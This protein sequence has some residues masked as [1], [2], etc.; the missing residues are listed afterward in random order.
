[1][2]EIASKSKDITYHQVSIEEF[3]DNDQNMIIICSHSFPY[4]K[5]KG[6]VTSKF[7][8]LLKTM[9]IYY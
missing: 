6:L 4:Y 2:L 3:Q 7:S 1:M 5:D 8:K 9:D